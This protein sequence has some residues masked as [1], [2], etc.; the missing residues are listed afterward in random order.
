[1]FSELAHGVCERN[2]SEST[3]SLAF[4]SNNFSLGFFT[5]I[6]L[7]VER[8]TEPLVECN[9]GLAVKP[10]PG[11]QGAAAYQALLGASRPGTKASRRF[12]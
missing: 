12:L 5:I 8:L 1:M 3:I 2:F 10:R 7:H 6:E 4:L 9:V 11:L